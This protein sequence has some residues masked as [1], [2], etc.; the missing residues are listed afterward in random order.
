M[1]R[2]FTLFMLKSWF[3]LIR[4]SIT[5]DSAMYRQAY[6][7]STVYWADIFINNRCVNCDPQ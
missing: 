3:V 5:A 2:S 6:P 4:L 1:H 7:R